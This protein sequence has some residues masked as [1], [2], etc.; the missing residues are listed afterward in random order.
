MDATR[1]VFSS[2][3]LSLLGRN[4]HARSKDTKTRRFIE[5]TL[6]KYHSLS[7]FFVVTGNRRC[8]LWNRSERI[9]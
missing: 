9:Y 7:F 8:A 1:R 6:L 2:S 5:K 3:S 4:V